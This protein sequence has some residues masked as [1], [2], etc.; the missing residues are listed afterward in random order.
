MD[1]HECTIADIPDTFFYIF[2]DENNPNP[3]CSEV[4]E[5]IMDVY[6]GNFIPHTRLLQLSG[7][8]FAQNI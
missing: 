1:G 7:L 2:G 4:F 3:T 6:E 5:S 8:I